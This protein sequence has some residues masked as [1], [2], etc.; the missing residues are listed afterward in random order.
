MAVI[1]IDNR[2]TQDFPGAM[3]V[4]TKKI[5]DFYPKTI[6]EDIT[7]LYYMDERFG[8][9]QP[10]IAWLTQRGKKYS[11]EIKKIKVSLFM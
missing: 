1:Y 6:N 2:M 11:I 9:N 4:L 10:V 8:F 5:G 7:A 3:E